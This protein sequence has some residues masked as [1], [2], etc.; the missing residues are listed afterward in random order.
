MR[1][2]RH[3]DRGRRGLEGALGVFGLDSRASC[4][5]RVRRLLDTE[6]PIRTA[7]GA[8]SL[9]GLILLAVVSLPHLR[10]AG[11]ATSADSQ[12]PAKESAT[13]TSEAEAATDSR[14]KDDQEFEL[15]VV[16]PDGKPIPEALVELRTTPSRRPNRSARA[17]SSGQGPYGA[18]VTTD[19]EG[20]L[21]VELPRAPTSFNVYIT[22][23]G[24]GPYWA[25]WS[26]ENSCRADSAPLHR[27]AG[28]GLVGGGNH[29]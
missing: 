10:A 29:R 24:Y 18:F 3:A 22:T 27:R 23:P 11:D 26:S 4:F 20:R 14:A 12:T 21:V 1:I 2:L 5:L 7:P 28:G 19:A 6:R 17:S 8:W 9:W 13:P 25:G 15:R 16:G